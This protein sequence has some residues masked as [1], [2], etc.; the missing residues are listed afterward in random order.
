MPSIARPGGLRVR[1]R[2]GKQN[3][4]KPKPY[5]EKAYLLDT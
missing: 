4:Q 3:P 2:A 1:L 5:L